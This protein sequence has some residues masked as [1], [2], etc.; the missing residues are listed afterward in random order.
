MSFGSS[1]RLYAKLGDAITKDLIDIYLNRNKTIFL[2]DEKG[3]RYRNSIQSAYKKCQKQRQDL[4]HASLWFEADWKKNNQN[5]YNH[6]RKGD[7]G[8]VR[9]RK[10][11][12]K[13]GC[14]NVDEVAKYRNY[15][16]HNRILNFSDCPEP[17]KSFYKKVLK[18]R[19]EKQKQ[20]K[21]QKN[22]KNHK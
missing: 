17:L 15:A 6:I 22:E 5:K 12:K 18:E 10:L 2:L 13:A 11:C 8:Q 9:F 21:G 1:W 3:K 14:E 20:W 4:M 7:G 16:L 19:T